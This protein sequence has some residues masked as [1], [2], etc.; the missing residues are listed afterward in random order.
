MP[1]AELV[2]GCTFD[3]ILLAPQFSVVESR[4]PASIDLRSRLTRRL[5]IS[6]PVVSANMDTVTRAPM[7]APTRSRPD[8]SRVANGRRRCR[9][10]SREVIRPASVPSGFTSGSFFTFRSIMRRSASGSVSSPSCSTRRSRGVIRCATRI[11]PSG[12][13]RRS[14]SVSRPTSLPAPSTTTRVPTRECSMAAAASASVASGPIVYGSRM[15]PCCV[16]LTICTSRTCGS[17]SPGRKP[18]SMIPI[19]PSSAMTMAMGARVTVSMLAETI[20]RFRKIGRAHV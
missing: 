4:D 17:I 3:D 9:T 8:S 7:A 2:H 1:L 19:P 13:N 14:R 18:R 11:V 15:I 6:R 16:R 5:T 20:G 10:R 12:T